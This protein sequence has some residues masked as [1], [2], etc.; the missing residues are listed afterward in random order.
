MLV[1]SQLLRVTSPVRVGAQLSGSIQR[2]SLKRAKSVSFEQTGTPCSIG[3]ALPG[4]GRS[5]RA[6]EGSGV[7][8]DAQERRQALP[9]QSHTLWSVQLLCQPCGCVP[10]L[11]C[12]LVH[13]VEQQVCVNEHQRALGPSSVSIASAT[14]EKS[15]PRPRSWAFWRNGEAW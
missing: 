8:R 5:E 13:C 1:V 14:L 9:G 6:L 3:D 2:S 11:R 7:G 12:A 15:I 4:C 10:M